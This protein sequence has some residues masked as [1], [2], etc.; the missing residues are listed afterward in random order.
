MLWV[1]KKKYNEMRE[2]LKYKARA[3]VRGDQEAIIDQQLNRSPTR[4]RAVV[5]FERERVVQSLMRLDTLLAN[6]PKGFGRL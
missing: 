4:V 1:L 3:T 5:A 2:L 6:E